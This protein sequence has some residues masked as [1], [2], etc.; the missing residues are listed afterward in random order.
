MALDNPP[1][2]AVGLGSWL[3]LPLQLPMFAWALKR[4]R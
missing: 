2:T 3:R 1:T 4:T